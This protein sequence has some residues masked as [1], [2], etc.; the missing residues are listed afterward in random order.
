VRR[1]L[2][3]GPW[4]AVGAVQ[5]AVFAVSLAVLGAVQRSDGWAEATTSGLIGGAFYGLINGLLLRSRRL[6]QPDPLADLDE[7]DRHRVER[8]AVRGP[9]P[10]NP[11]VR[12]AAAAH[13][14]YQLELLDRGPRI[15]ALI[16]FAVF[17]VA[18]LVAA[19]L[20]G[21]WLYWVLAVTL[22]ALIIDG[23]RRPQRL[24]R[25]LAL[26]VAQDGDAGDAGPRP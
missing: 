5:G 21:T 17:L 16:V 3:T 25:R 8:A 14:R 24:Q 13:T 6:N 19:V 10:A 9:I 22:V 4:W 26:L 23:V 18:D 12:R 15:Q 7:T 11:E 2:R 20:I 1:F